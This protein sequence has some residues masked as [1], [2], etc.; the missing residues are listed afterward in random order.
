MSVVIE[1]MTGRHGETVL[2]IYAEGIETGQATFET[3]VGTW[4]SWDASHL[5]TC[6]LVAREGDTVAGWAALSPVSRR[7]VY[8]GV[9]EVSVYVGEA[10]R[11]RG[12]GRMLLASLVNASE[13]AG[14]WTLEAKIFPANRV[15]VA[16]HESLGFRIVG[17]RNDSVAVTG[18]GGTCFS[19]SDAAARPGP[20]PPGS[21][22]TPLWAR[23]ACRRAECPRERRGMRS[24]S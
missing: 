19:W 14:I 16:L 20:R 11:E 2:A 3:E 18:C 17:T 6:R 24:T 12:I 9:A 23:A 4:D 13:D 1:S 7:P 8:R 10:H 21:T 22:S 15:S 5:E